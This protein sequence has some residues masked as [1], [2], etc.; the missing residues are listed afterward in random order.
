MSGRHPRFITAL[1]EGRY[2]REPGLED[3]PAPEIWHLDGVPWNEALLP[4]LW[5]RCW[6][7]SYGFPSTGWITYRCACG[8][9]SLDGDAWID[10]NSRRR[11]M[12]ASKER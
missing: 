11:F 1:N 2:H 12:R 5:H 9:V 10:R 7:Q 3:R 4:W 8:A 6:P